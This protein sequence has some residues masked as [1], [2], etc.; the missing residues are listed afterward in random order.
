MMS[1]VKCRNHTTTT[2]DTHTFTENNMIIIFTF[3]ADIFFHFNNFLYYFFAS[4]EW[5]IEICVFIRMKNAEVSN[6]KKL[7]LFLNIIKLKI[8][9]NE[10]L[11][12]INWG[13]IL[14][15]SWFFIMLAEWVDVDLLFVLSCEIQGQRT[16]HWTCLGHV[17]KI[18]K[19]SKL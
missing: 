2:N 6:D 5:Y 15:F 9:S 19:N 12:I 4:N 10:I 18:L 7:S 1:L 14:I 3:N 16:E 17:L 11:V 8:F 13:K